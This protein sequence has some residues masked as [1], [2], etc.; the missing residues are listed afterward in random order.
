M[1]SHNR[2]NDSLRRRISRQKDNSRLAETGLY[3][4]RP[5]DCIQ[6]KRWVAAELK[7]YQ[8]WTQKEWGVFFSVMSRNERDSLRVFTWSSLSSL[9]QQI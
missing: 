2:S 5:F 8:S 3:A 4:L 1:T 7:T 6:Q 9:L